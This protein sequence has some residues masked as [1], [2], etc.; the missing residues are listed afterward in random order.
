VKALLVFFL[1]VCQVLA[2]CTPARLSRLQLPD[3]SQRSEVLVYREPAFNAGG[4][5]MVFGAEGKDYVSL[6]NGEYA[7]MYFLPGAYN[8]FVR[9]N[10][11][12]QPFFLPVSLSTNDKKCIKAY[13]TPANI[14]KVLLPFIYHFSNTFLLEEVSCLSEGELSKY[15][16]VSVEHERQ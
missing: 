2:S 11:A 16:A 9:S 4:V 8:F 6:W 12:D 1:L 7:L 14:G 10:Q 5:S 13:P 3:E 15:S